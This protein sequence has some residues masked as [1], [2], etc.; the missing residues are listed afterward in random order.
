MPENSQIRAKGVGKN[1]VRHDLDG[2]PGLAGS[3]LQQG[4]VSQLEAGQ[5]A[6]QNTQQAQQVQANA[7]QPPPAPGAGP[8]QVPDPV[9]FAMGKL[10][11]GDLQGAGQQVLEQRDFSR[12]LPLLRKL[13]VSPTSSGI[14]QR[15]YVERLSKEANRPLGGSATVIRQRDFDAR[16]EQF[17]AG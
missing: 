8:M 16:L 7:P 4:E 15:A 13:A 11:G 17:N 12:W 2:T 5:K 6:V 14:L 9:Q 10:G 3:D 1:A